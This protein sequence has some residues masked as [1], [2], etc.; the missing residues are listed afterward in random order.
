MYFA[1]LPRP[2]LTQTAVY[3]Y[4]WT[5]GTRWEGWGWTDRDTWGG[6]ATRCPDWRS[7]L[8]NAILQASRGEEGGENQVGGAWGRLEDGG[9]QQSFYIHT[10]RSRRLVWVKVKVFIWIVSFQ[11]LVSCGLAGLTHVPVF[12]RVGGD[13]MNQMKVKVLSLF[14]DL[15]VNFS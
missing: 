1:T 3:C 11:S 8:P 14:L 12:S 10:K 6:G 9:S 15:I 2:A 13:E 5:G 7:P 4:W